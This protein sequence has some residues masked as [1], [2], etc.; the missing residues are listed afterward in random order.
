MSDTNIVTEDQ[1]RRHNPL[2]PVVVGLIR[3]LSLERDAHDSTKVVLNEAV[4]MMGELDRKLDG[5]RANRLHLLAQYRAAMSGRT[6]AE[7]RQA[8]A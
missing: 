3:A 2:A 7:E 6:N 4:T 1:T 5:E 8:A